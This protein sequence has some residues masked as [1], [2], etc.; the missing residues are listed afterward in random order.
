ME[1]DHRNGLRS[2]HVVKGYARISFYS[3]LDLSRD[4]F[5]GISDLLGT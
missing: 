3:F 5:L 1:E 2:K 4:L